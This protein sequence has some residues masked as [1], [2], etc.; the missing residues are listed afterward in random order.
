MAGTFLWYFIKIKQVVSG[1]KMFIDAWT[2]GRPDGHTTDNRPWHKLAGLWPVEL[3]ITVEWRRK[4]LRLF[5]VGQSVCLDNV[6]GVF[7]NK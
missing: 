6:S 3:K 5:L 4:D 1:K 7:I 2:D